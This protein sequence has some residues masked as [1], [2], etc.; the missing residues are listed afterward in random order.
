MY[1]MTFESHITETTEITET[2][3]VKPPCLQVNFIQGVDYLSIL[4]N[5]N[6]KGK[7]QDIMAKTCLKPKY[8]IIYVCFLYL[9]M[10][11]CWYKCSFWGVL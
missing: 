4:R 11:L 2:T 8:M 7:I 5:S 1:D 6:L 3:S 10:F 9:G